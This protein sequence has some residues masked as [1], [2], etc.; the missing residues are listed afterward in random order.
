MDLNRAMI[1]GR[2]TRDPESRTT[3]QG[4]SVCSFSLAT[5]F[6]WVD[7]SGQRQEKVE[8][9]NIVAWR[10]LA[11]I[12]QQYLK[13]GGKVYIEGRLQTRDWEGQDGVKRY[14]TEIVAD[15]M[16]MLDRADSAGRSATVSSSNQPS[17]DSFMPTAPVTEIPV[18]SGSADDEIKVENIP[19]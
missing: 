5:N 1:I 13:K 2:L 6:V 3:P 11:D 18:Q 9:H 12:C 10:K 17:A 19:F 7:Q 14:R 15:N 4:T 8:Y 16:I